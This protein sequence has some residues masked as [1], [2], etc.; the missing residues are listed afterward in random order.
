MISAELALLA[1]AGRLLLEYNESSGQ[2]DRTLRATAQAIVQ[3]DCDVDVTYR[4]VSIALGDRAPLRFP[5]PE[6]RYNAALQAR[7]HAILRQV[8]THEIEVAAALSLL[9]HVEAGTPHH[10]R[11]LSVLLLGVA[12]AS[13]ARL[14]GADGGTVVVSGLATALGLVVRQELGRRR[15]NTL[16]L[17]LAAGFIGAAIGGLSIRFGWTNTPALVLLVPS[18]MLIPGPHLI[19]CLLDLVDN[20]LPMSIARL[21]FATSVM[22]ASV[23]GIVLGIAMSLGELPISEQ[24]VS[25]GLNVFADMI[26]AGLV[27]LG[28]AAFYNTLWRHMALAVAGGMIGHGTRFAALAQD[29]GL[30]SATFVGGF[31][32]GIVAALIVRTFR[33]PLAVVAFAGAVTMMPG[34][35]IYRAA[36]GSLQLARFLGSAELPTVAGTLGNALQASFVVIALALGLIIASSA[37]NWFAVSNR[38][39]SSADCHS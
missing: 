2:I 35:Q 37:I 30:I 9:E 20:F 4:G 5:V 11:W 13:L 3:D 16:A 18:L 28:F 14:L 29:W 15:V 8:R 6:L 21:G 10:A 24:V 38:D 17:P 25:K 32:V 22:V 12:A 36:S 23:V 34:M 19:N 39:H 7:V 33:V 26:L 1:N 31:A 27:T